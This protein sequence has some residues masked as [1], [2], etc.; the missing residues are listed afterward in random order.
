MSYK[1]KKINNRTERRDYTKVSGELPLPNLVEIQTDTFKWF[2]NEGIQEVFDE[3]FPITSPNGQATLAMDS[4]EFREPRITIAQ[5]KE[6]SKVYDAPIYANL[7]LTINEP[8][9]TISKEGLKIVNNDMAAF[10]KTWL[11]E[12]LDNKNILLK[13]HA[14]NLYFY[15]AKVKGNNEPDTIEVEV[16]E[17]TDENISLRLT[18]YKKGEVFMGDFPLM[19]EAGTFIINGSQKVIV[20]QLVRSPGSYFNKEINRKNGE[21]IYSANIIPSR[22][23]WLE[24]ETESKKNADGDNAEALFVKIDK[25]RK[26]TG[27]SLL[28]ALGMK[29]QEVLDLFDNSQ[30]IRNTYEQDDL[31]GDWETDWEHAVQEIYK[32]IRQGE[33][34]TADGASK[35]LDALL[36][37]KRKYDLTKAGRFKLNEKLTIKN[38][39]LGTTFAEDIVD[40]NGKVLIAKDTLVS[41]ENLEEVQ[42]ILDGDVMMVNIDF[43]AD[44]DS[45][46]QIQKIKVYR[47]NDLKTKT[48]T[49][50]G[51][52]GKSKDEFLN[53]GDIL[54]TISYAENLRYN[55][56]EVD[57]IDHLGNRRVRTVGELLQ[58]QL[59]IGMIRIEKNV[60]EKLSTSQ[61]FK[62]KPS[63]IINNKPLTAVIGEFFN[64]SQLS[65]FMDQIN[66]LS[67][68]TNKRRLTALGPG[69]LSRDRAG[70]EVRDVHESHYGRI[71][72]IETPEGPNIGLINNLATYAKVNEYGFITTPYRKVNNGKIDNNDIRYLTADEESKYIIAQANVRQSKDGD[73]LDETV[74]S[75]YKGDDIIANTADVDFIDVSPKQ[76][77]S[78]ATACIPFLENDDANRALMGA[79]MQ[80]QAVPLL[81]PQAPLVGTG[82]EFEAA[83]DS[84]SAVVA[85]EDGI[86][87]YVDSKV[88]TVET[89]D[90]THTYQLINFERSNNGTAI[91]QA[92]IVKVG[93]QVKKGEIIA[94]GPSMD[95]GELAI[96]QN[97]VV[98]FTTYNGYNYEDAIIMSERVTQED[99]F[100]SI[101]V[102]E[103]TIERRNTKQGEEEITRE[104]PNISDNAKKYLDEDGI[105]AIGT[106]VHQGDI[107]VGKVTPKGQ[108]QLSPEDKLL[109]AIFGEKSRN[110][111]DNSLRVPNGGDGIVQSVKRFTREDGYDLAPDIL[112]V[113]KVY[114]VQKRKIQEGDKM[115]GRHGN[116]G[117]ISRIL[118]IEDM[119]HLE[120]GTPVDIML[121][122]QGVPSRMNIGQ[123]LEIHLGMA[124]KK[125]GVK[126]ATPVFEGLTDE[127][128][129]DI[130]KEAGMTNFGKVKLIDG[131]TGEPMDK[132]IAVGVM[133]MLKLSHMVDDKLHARNVGPYSLITQQPLGGKAQ[134][135]GQRFGEMEV[136]ALEAYGAAYTL[137]EIL[138]IKS[139]DIKGRVKTYEAIVRS[140]PIPEPGIPESFNVLTKEIMG[141]GF[142]MF[143]VDKDGNKTPISA[144][145]G[146][147]DDEIAPGEEFYD[148]N[149]TIV[150][151]PEDAGVEVENIDTDSLDDDDLPNV[152]K[153][154]D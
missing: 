72:P 77:F 80:R 125:L 70:L 44:I 88:I 33:T 113:I 8:N 83:R 28:T 117:V 47:D 59:R 24:F 108:V 126:V 25:S 17:E 122:P 153:N 30:L 5:A 67:E 128:L 139:D 11:E 87:R 118:P 75:R 124:A 7:T 148:E 147:D 132:P 142:D 41:K 56:G 145:D 154:D 13:K 45:P 143:M 15:E 110:V 32:K 20:S 119:P 141:L 94:D 36:F 23:T 40:K 81:N 105:V 64:L 97:V 61:L 18:V 99:R 63:T 135:G 37:D 98:A 2:Q 27:T 69:G 102:D 89:K 116:K 138:T 109:N 68:L 10:I 134:N 62:V 6:E 71:C 57:D 114:I 86:V 16:L 79:N 50:L 66:P 12:K 39:I 9:E 3:I 111:K 43:D 34:A 129:D 131:A 152:E 51:I 78:I 92:P 93:D 133:Y 151:N 42:N 140:K 146:N 19:T 137:R 103:Y 65:Q 95:N 112:E 38:R 96:G 149:R 123:I 85:K 4:W 106:E 1:I 73:I 136:W 76:I 54:A 84:G 14:D 35:F 31:S 26:T 48:V 104:L 101:H 46:K 120:D 29:P 100:T 21:M 130:M 90:G 74:I 91:S 82:V 150:E 127:E 144:Y 22:G 49:L 60:R 53:V 121:N 52:S 107:L 115:S 58:N 55:I